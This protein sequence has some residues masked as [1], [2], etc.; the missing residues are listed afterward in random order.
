MRKYIFLTTEGTTFQP[1]STSSEPDIENM[2][3]IGFAIGNTVKDAAIKLTEQNEYL[4][5]TTFDEIFAIQL[6]D[7]NR[8]YISLREIF[9]RSGGD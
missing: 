4:A 7:D 9:Q 2:Q 1:D 8:E 3:V 5:E 6:A